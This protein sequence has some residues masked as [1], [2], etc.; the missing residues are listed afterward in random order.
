MEY[1]RTVT[2][3]IIQVTL[4]ENLRGYWDDFHKIDA[5]VCPSYLL[6]SSQTWT[7]SP[8]NAFCFFSSTGPPS[9]G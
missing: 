8:D 4:S 1:V 9:R 3:P 2:E 7:F 6:S 5:E